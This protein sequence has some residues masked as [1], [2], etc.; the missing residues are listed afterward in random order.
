MNVDDQ[1]PFAQA[2][3]ELLGVGH[4]YP[5]IAYGTLKTK[6]AF[7]L[8]ARASKLNAQT[9]N[10]V[11]S[12]IE[13]YERAMQFA[14]EDDKELIS[15]DDY[16]EPQ[17]IPYIENS[18]PY[19]GIIVSKSP[20][21]CGFLIYNGDI[22]SEIGLIRVASKAGKKSVMC[23]VIDGATADAFGYV[24]N[25]LLVVAVIKINSQ[26]MQRAGLPQYSSQDIILRTA[27]DSKTWDVFANG[28]TQGINQCQRAATIQKLMQYKP[29]EL[30]DLC[31]FVA[32]I[33]PGFKTQV[34]QFLARQK[35][36]YKVP[37]FDKLLR[38]DSSG[39]AW[40]LYQENAMA[41]LNLAGFDMAR[42]Y[43]IIKAISKKKTKV[44]EAAHDEFSAGFQN[45]LTEKQHVKDA[46]A[47]K[48]TEVVWKVIEDSANYSFNACVSG[49]TRLFTGRSPRRSL[50]VKELYE[51]GKK[52]KG[53]GYAYSMFKDGRVRKNKI[54]DIREAGYQVIFQVRTGG[55]ACIE[56]T[57][58]HKFPTPK[59]KRPLSKLMVGD[60]LYV[61][62][63]HAKK[64]R[65]ETGYS[66]EP[67]AILSI[68]PEFVVMTY[69]IEMRDP[70]H[71]FVVESGIVTSN[72]HAGCVALDALYGA[73]LK[74]HYPHTYYEV[75]LEDFLKKGNK[76]KIAEIKQEM[77]TAYN[78]QVVPCRY[79]QDNRRFVIDSKENYISD[80]LASIKSVSQQAANTLYEL[81]DK[82]FDY[83]VDLLAELSESKTINKTVVDAL[84]DVGYFAEFGGVIKLRKI[85]WE[86]RNGNNRLTKQ[87]VEKTKVKRMNAL[88]EY[89]KNLPDEDI[90]PKE[91]VALEIECY[92]FPMTR[93]PQAHSDYAV[94]EIAGGKTQRL[95]LYN[96]RTGRFGTGKIPAAA[97]KDQ[98]VKVGDV[99]HINGWQMRTAYGYSS[100]V[101]VK[102]PYRELWITDYVVL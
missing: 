21:P 74:A 44:I 49:K 51:K 5:M 73:Y 50:T 69:D 98:P 57:L 41:A 61:V 19:L 66:V 39:S 89:E 18:A 43:P 30:R 1:A 8:Y 78:I 47:E 94:I 76:D 13:R 85:A 38:N 91:H 71:N 12:Q 4:S 81:R 55:G 46:D 54:V 90:T 70:A 2:Q 99:I 37:P 33:R 68:K 23:T 20:H 79:R 101:R 87:L 102:L 72:S 9:A 16:V 34:Q 27:N 22:R 31:A 7:K 14:E 56:C 10:E 53:F 86:F 59:G 97:F 80:S 65:G 25:D 29:R 45:Y 6:S 52:R 82:Q 42:T 60:E 100:G 48:Q 96:M 15:L 93:D 40:M 32:A 24:K 28:W 95:N 75:L 67:R 64:K 36:K 83:F 77:Q 3:E 92:G 84:I 62:N 35:F 58:E 17:Y 11:S 63:E 88:R 26:T